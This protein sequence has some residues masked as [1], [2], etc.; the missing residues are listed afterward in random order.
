MDE[1]R[2]AR[3]V[4]HRQDR[5]LGVPVTKRL[6]TC[7]VAVMRANQAVYTAPS[8]RN[9]ATELRSAR[10]QMYDLCGWCHRRPIKR[11]LLERFGT[12]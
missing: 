6:D 5:R 7:Q 3:L 2:E 4:G 10:A 9:G 1:R 8:G 12:P 11:C